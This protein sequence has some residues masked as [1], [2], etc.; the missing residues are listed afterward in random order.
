MSPLK[1][2]TFVPEHQIASSKEQSPFT[3]S[4]TKTS[5]IYFSKFDVDMYDLNKKVIRLYADLHAK[6]IAWKEIEK[7]TFEDL[8]NTRT[9]A[10]NPTS[11]AIVLSIKKL[12]EKIGVTI[13]KPIKDIPV[14]EYNDT[15]VGK[16]HVI[17]LKKYV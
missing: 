4:I 16:F 2:Y 8:K 14:I 12:L 10:V 5:S 15:L 9:L 11:G 13:T 3:V 6:T 17:D 1:K 7:G